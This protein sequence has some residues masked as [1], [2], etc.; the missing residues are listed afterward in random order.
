[1]ENTLIENYICQLIA[2][3][4]GS[5]WIDEN[6]KKKIEGLSEED[7][8]MKPL[9]E[10]HSVA[11]LISHLLQWRIA[12]LKAFAGNRYESIFELPANWKN[13]EQLRQMGWAKLR[14]EFY[15]S[16]QEI[17]GLL[18]KQNDN[19]LENIYADGYNLNYLLAGML[20]HDLYH[21]GQIGI[22]VKLLKMQLTVK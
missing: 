20:H 2:I 7:A 17:I 11:E 8:F 14:D 6:F 16:H 10:V 19:W 22:T 12:A 13:N 21:L 15:K 4:D 3:N 1:M 5:P 18:E 9:P